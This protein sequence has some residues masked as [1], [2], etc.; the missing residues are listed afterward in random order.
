MP[1]K[2]KNS[3]GE[4]RL[5]N[6]LRGD[7]RTHFLS[8]GDRVELVLADVLVEAGNQ[9]RYVYF[10]MG[11]HIS[12]ISSVDNRAG[13]EV[14]LIGNEGMFGIPLVLGVNVSSMRAIVQGAGSALRMNAGRFNREL[15]QRPALQ[16]KL[17][18]YIY[19]QMTQLAQTSAC[20]R[21][22]LVEARLAR[23]LLMTRDRVGS[24]EFHITH[25]FLAYMLGVRRVGVT[26]AAGLLQKRK[27][28]SYSR[29]AIRILDGDGLEAVSCGCYRAD[30]ITYDTFMG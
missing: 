19:V 12:L 11:S 13:I 7:E 4:N 15:K 29:G 9:I 26:T 20:T 3:M 30:R 22:H 14:A 25:E 23:W 21:F 6:V 27:L 16:V 24:D 2:P 8:R 10:P 17:N 18:R 28:I 1:I 5:V